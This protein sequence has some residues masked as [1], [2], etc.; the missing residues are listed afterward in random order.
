MKIEWNQNPLETKVFLDDSDRKYLRLAIQFEAA[1]S[2]ISY[3]DLANKKETPEDIERY[4]K[5]VDYYDRI[6]FLENAEHEAEL[7][8]EVKNYEE[9]LQG[10]H[11][12][13][14]TCF[15]A[16]CSKCWAES[17]LGIDTIAGLGK[18]EGSAIDSCY[19]NT[20]SKPWSRVEKTIDEVIKELSK[21]MKREK[22]EAWKNQTQEEY[23][24]HIPRW[25]AEHKRAR[26]WLKKYKQ[27]HGF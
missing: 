21:P 12:G 3:R 19:W 26:E 27:E 20:T 24:K 18:H 16:T 23:E 17:L 8:E 2:A 14:C 13:D 15:P 6:V 7:D 10:Y 4:K 1:T 25:E 9:D 22:N 11:I 5:Y